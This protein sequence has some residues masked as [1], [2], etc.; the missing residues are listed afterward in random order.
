MIMRKS[1]SLGF[2]N[3]CFALRKLR[4]VLEFLFIGSLDEGDD[5]WKAFFGRRVTRVGAF[6][7]A[8]VLVIAGITERY[9]D[10]HLW[11][12]IT[13]AFIMTGD[14]HIASCG[15]RSY[16]GRTNTYRRKQ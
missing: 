4:E 5:E 7:L 8:V 13:A 12:A 15:Q 1:F 6:L 11:T 10:E 16:A 14:F 9:S 2:L 3:S